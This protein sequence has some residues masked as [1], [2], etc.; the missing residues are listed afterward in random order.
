VNQTRR[1][2]KTLTAIEGRSLRPA[3]L[4]IASLIEWRSDTMVELQ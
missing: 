2:R 1:M 3:R 4:F